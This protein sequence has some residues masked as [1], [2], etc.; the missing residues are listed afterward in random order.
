MSVHLF[1]PR[2]LFVWCRLIHAVEVAF[3]SIDASRPE[4]PELIQ[5]G[6]HLGKG[7]RPQ[8]VKTALRV[9]RRF[10]ETG[11]PQHA[12]VLRDGR[13]GHVKPSLDLSNGVLGRRQ[14]AQDRAPVRLRNDFKNAG[15]A[16][17]I[18]Q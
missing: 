7:F 16:Q 2:L 10:Y 1:S 6:I 9:D 8:P 18:L 3:E 17:C 13:L 5:P 14:Q 12:Q 11:V 4:T 15:H